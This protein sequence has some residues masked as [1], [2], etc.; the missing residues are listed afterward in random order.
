[1]RK[2]IFLKSIVLYLLADATLALGCEGC[3]HEYDGVV[4]WRG[5]HILSVLLAVHT[6]HRTPVVQVHQRLKQ[7]FLLLIIANINS[8]KY[9]NKASGIEK[10]GL[11]GKI[12]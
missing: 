2:Q 12:I 9:F 1:M 3:Q 5:F 10:M 7:E 6:D 11:D 8:Y 4:T